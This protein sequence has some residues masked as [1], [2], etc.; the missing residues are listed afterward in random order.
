MWGREWTSSLG[1]AVL[2]GQRAAARAVGMLGARA[3][4]SLGQQLFFAVAVDELIG[5]KFPG[6]S[7]FY[8]KIHLP[9]FF[10]LML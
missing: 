5:P 1:S 10:L 8:T 9:F 3:S 4:A 7:P 2:R 6:D